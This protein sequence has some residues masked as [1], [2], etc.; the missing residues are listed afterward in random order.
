MYQYKLSGLDNVWLVNGYT[1]EQTPYGEAVHIDH[2]NELD[3]VIALEL[4][5]QQDALTAAEF[6]FIRQQLGMSQSDVGAF[7]GVD[8]QTVARWEKKE[9]PLPPYADRLMR[10]LFTGHQVKDTSIYSLVQ[11]FNAID[12][13]KNSRIVLTKSETWQGELQPC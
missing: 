2:A 9:T 11:T 13:A 5:K 4:V 12:K 3:T 6:R 1:I 7:M 8:N 10:V